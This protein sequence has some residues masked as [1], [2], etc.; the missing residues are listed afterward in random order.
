VRLPKVGESVFAYS[1]SGDRIGE[2][3]FLCKTQENASDDLKE[4][5]E[6][7]AKQILEFMECNEGCTLREAQ[8]EVGTSIIW[9]MTRIQ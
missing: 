6:E 1:L 8:R 5:K 3:Q 4:V 2:T 9:K 7:I